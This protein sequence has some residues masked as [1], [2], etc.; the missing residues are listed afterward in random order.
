MSRLPSAAASPDLIRAIHIEG[1][2][3]TLIGASG[4]VLVFQVPK[5]LP[6]LPSRYA[7]V[8]GRLSS[9]RA[10][11]PEAPPL[12]SLSSGPF[13]PAPGTF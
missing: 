13:N 11:A 6:P 5:G 12:M 3:T 8:L 1:V 9:L 10:H 7:A 2:F 4:I